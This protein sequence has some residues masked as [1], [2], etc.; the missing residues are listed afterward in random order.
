MVIDSDAIARDIL[1]TAE[2]AAEL[3]DWWGP[4]VLD[5]GGAID[6]AAVAK[7]VFADPV[8]RTRL[9]A[10]VHPKVHAERARQREAAGPE[11]GAI[12][13]DAPLLIEAGI[14]Q[15]CDVVVFIE[16]PAEDR[17]D[18]VHRTRGWTADQLQARESAQI[19]LDTKRSRAN[20]ILA[21][22]GTLDLLR[23]RAAQLLT[24]ICTSFSIHATG[25]KDP[26]APDQSP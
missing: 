7:Q 19:G 9:E 16:S 1:N 2:A 4:S 8:A 17:I 15:L 21:N 5:A 6:R 12:V 3:S 22:D 18:R 10:W 14:D 20:H 11:I 25:P 26:A 13:E 24:D 23:E